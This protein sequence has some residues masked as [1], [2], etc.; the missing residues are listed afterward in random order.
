M[1]GITD[2]VQSK[3]RGSTNNRVLLL[4]CFDIIEDLGEQSPS[5]IGES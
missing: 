3:D 5:Y 1:V 2:L 4:S